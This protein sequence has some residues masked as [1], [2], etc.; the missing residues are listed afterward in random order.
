MSNCLIEFNVI[1][2]IITTGG[3]C[4]FPRLVSLSLSA[5]VEYSR[6]FQVDDFTK[7]KS[8]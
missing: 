5:L 8:R 6:Q 3:G 2:I 1:L 4:S 7:G